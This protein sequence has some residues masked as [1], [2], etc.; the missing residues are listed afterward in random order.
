M[1]FVSLL[2]PLLVV[3]LVV[4]ALF[5]VTG[6][7]IINE[8][9]VGVVV[10]RFAGKSL[11]PDRLIALH[12]EAGYQADTLAPGFHLGYFPWVY[13]IRKVPVTVIPQGEIGL[14]VAADG[15]SIP[16]ERILGKVVDSDDFQDAR[17]F[18]SNGG[19]KG[20]QLG[21][22]TAGAY[23]INTALFT[24]ITRANAEMNDMD[25]HDLLVYS[26]HP[27]MVG[28]VTT[29]DGAPIPEGEIAGLYL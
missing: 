1:D 25:A 24:V 16:P 8:R 9:Q 18:L 11:P 19:E 29:L 4:A 28:I 20:R 17:K 13:N 26:I 6:L 5:A 3:V 12:G 15:S 23:R 7:V 10:K 22:L 2:I 14:V 21:I 27:D